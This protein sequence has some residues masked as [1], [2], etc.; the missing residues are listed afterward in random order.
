MKIS[1]SKPNTEYVWRRLA[2]VLDR[3]RR[4]IT[5]PP[6]LYERTCR[7]TVDQSFCFIFHFSLKSELGHSWRSL[8]QVNSKLILLTYCYSLFYY[9][10][11]FYRAKAVSVV[12]PL[13]FR[14]CGNMQACF[15]KIR[16]KL[17]VAN[18]IQLR[19][20]QT[21]YILL[22]FKELVFPMQSCDVVSKK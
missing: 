7:F 10:T 5:K 15:F 17:F 13:H 6:C 3:K 12:C 22:R 14:R 11:L 19:P 18:Y 2:L 4:Q 9:S 8:F 16:S 21:E 1:K 20:A